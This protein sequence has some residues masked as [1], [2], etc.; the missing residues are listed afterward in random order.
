VW[1]KIKT[2]MKK[3]LTFSLV[4]MYLVAWLPAASVVH[5]VDA[6]ASCGSGAAPACFYYS[7]ASG[8][9]N[10]VNNNITVDV[11][12][13][14]GNQ[15]SMGADAWAKFNPAELQFVSGDY[16]G[17]TNL[18]STNHPVYPQKITN[19]ITADSTGLIKLTRLIN[20]TSPAVYNKGRGILARLT[21]RPLGA[22]GSQVTL[23]FNYTANQGS[24][25]SSI[26]GTVPG[27]DILGAAPSATLTLASGGGDQTGVMDRVEI[28]PTSATVAP[29]GTQLFT[30][31]A[32]TSNGA[33]ITSGVTYAW[34]KTGEGSVSPAAGAIST[35]TAG[36]NTGTAT[37]TVTATQTSGTTTITKTASATVT[38]SNSG[39]FNP[40]NPTA[41]GPYITSISPS[42]GQ[43]DATPQVAIYGGNF[44][45]Y[46][47]ATNKVYFG[48]KEA[49]VLDWS[50]SRIIV[51]VPAASDITSRL[52]VTVRVIT[53][54][55]KTAEYL[56]Y[57]YT[58]TAVGGSGSLP[59][60]GPETYTWFG[61][62]LA[63]AG[64]AGLTYMKLASKKL[65]STVS[66]Q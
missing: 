7:P 50:N 53:S 47:S 49:T 16:L 6:P 26:A 62:V 15:D 28:V 31:T 35:Y 51:R 34:T 30:A 45:T 63:A 64:F 9:I 18:D 20:F 3:F 52:T 1:A 39:P 59:S 48:M 11:A 25:D 4:L 23:S 13:D 36:A 46:D 37:V 41:A 42:Y 32:K 65:I 5:A 19:P 12:F 60:N 8:N 10:V 27:V 61:L 24:G 2:K 66:N 14:T 57:T 56:G 55:E 17:D 33:A 43:K 54:D 44:G 29:A 21:F 40:T 58:M 38:I 22:I